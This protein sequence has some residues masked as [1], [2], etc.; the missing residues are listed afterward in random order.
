MD[1]AARMYLSVIA[2]ECITEA[3]RYDAEGDDFMAT[4][5]LAIAFEVMIGTSSSDETQNL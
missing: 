1:A 5:M 2:Q 3:L 4:L